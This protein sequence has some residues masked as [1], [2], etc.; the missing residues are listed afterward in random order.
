MSNTSLKTSAEW[1]TINWR[2]LERVV[3]KLQKRIYQASLR[4]DTKVVRRLQK[5][6]MKS[7]SAKT[8]AV[9]KVTQDNQGK[10]TAGIDGVK[11]LTPKQRLILILNLKISDKAQ[12]TRRVWI[13]KPGKDEKRPLGIPT[14][15]DRATQSLAKLALEPEWEAK[16]EPNSFGFRPGRSCHDAI[17]AIFDSI[18]TK[19]KW[20]LD[21]DITQCFDNIN[22]EKLLE[23][24]NTFPTLRRQIK[25]WLK[26]GVMDNFKFEE[27]SNGT[28]Q[29]GV[30]SP[31]LA[32]IA[33]HGMEEVVKRYAETL[34]GSKRD[35]R[36]SI[37]LIRYADDF[38]ILHPEYKVVERCSQIIDA[39]LDDIGL[40]I[41]LKKTQFA[42]TLD[43][44]TKINRAEDNLGLLPKVSKDNGFNFL[45]FNIRQYPTGKGHSAKSNHGKILGFQTYITPSKEATKKHYDSLCKIIDS[46]KSGTQ[47]DLIRRLNTVING[48]T[49][50]YSTVSSKRTFTELDW[51][52]FNKLQSWAKHRHRGKSGHWITDRYWHT[53]DNN[54]WVFASKKDG[55]FN[56][57]LSR[58]AETKII[59]HVKVKGNSSPFDGNIIYWSSRK[60]SNPLVPKNVATLL[61]KQKGKCAYC[62]AIFREEDVIEIDHIKPK[63]KGGKDVYDNLQL[64]HRH[65]HDEK[66]AR[67]GK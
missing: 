66:T 18:N 26:S 13:P 22:H 67:D 65:C 49:R 29:G 5:T 11:S 3:Y 7:W 63:A 58:H 35:N 60:G 55:K 56:I 25:A 31:L 47:E 46:H 52:L 34:P 43:S 54:N 57:I 19:P 21:A 59:R 53:I 51:M 10:K 6:L 62:G 12:P 42:H 23:K 8:L 44:S 16:F 64:L 27:T 17:S 1:N 39:W 4:G 24:I 33:L 15:Q 45:G 28:P 9:R 48:W 20:V 30:I 50:Y 40:G 41:N 61:K 32:N 38:V 36:T 2:K 37:A 14:I